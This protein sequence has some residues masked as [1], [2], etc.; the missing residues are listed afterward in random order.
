MPTKTLDVERLAR[1]LGVRPPPLPLSNKGQ[2]I[3]A[4]LLGKLALRHQAWGAA[5]QSCGSVS[6]P[7]DAAMQ[8]QP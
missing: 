6:L 1:E 4:A 3:A 5:S 7:P 8:Q 2:E